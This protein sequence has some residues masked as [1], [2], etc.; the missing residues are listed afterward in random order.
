MPV[1]NTLI[2]AKD[3]MK[4]RLKKSRNERVKKY[5]PVTWSELSSV[6]ERE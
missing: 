3:F 4:K 2:F 1:R 5:L 6:Y